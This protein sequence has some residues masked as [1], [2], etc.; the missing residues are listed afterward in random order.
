MIGDTRSVDSTSN[1]DDIGRAR[2]VSHANPAPFGDRS[3]IAIAAAIT[4]Q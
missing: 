4:S 1:D 2:H 3:R